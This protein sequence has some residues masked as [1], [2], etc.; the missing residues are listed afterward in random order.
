IAR[1]HPASNAISRWSFQVTAAGPGDGGPLPIAGTISAKA[2]FKS[3]GSDD[4]RRPRNRVQLADRGLRPSVPTRQRPEPPERP[5][6]AGPAPRDA[7]LPARRSSP[8]WHSAAARRYR[9]HHPPGQRPRRST[10]AERAAVQRRGARSPSPGRRVAPRARGA[11]PTGRSALP[12]TGFCRGHDLSPRSR[13]SGV[14]GIPRGERVGTGRGVS[15]GSRRVASPRTSLPDAAFTAPTR[16][17]ALDV[18]RAAARA[19]WRG[20]GLDAAPVR[21]RE[22]VADHVHAEGLAVA[23][24]GHPEM[25][26]DPSRRPMLG[27]G[28]RHDALEADRSEAVMEGGAS[29]LRRETPTP[30]LARE[31]IQDLDVGPVRKMIEATL[32]DEPAVDLVDHGPDSPAVLSPVSSEMGERPLRA[33]R[34]RVG[35]ERPAREKARDLGIGVERGVGRRIRRDEGPKLQARRLEDG[36]SSLGVPPAR[37]W[38]AWWCTISQSP[39]R[40]D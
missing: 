4:A 12:R 17:P 34:S 30:M 15:A 25:L 2:S 40:R 7:L 13:A 16:P 31:R 28:H 8:R 14:L 11:R 6:R 20:I 32:A 37:M 3:L 23:L 29:G 1:P 18:P 36:H 27:A 39:P 26:H 22:S 35:G 24:V 38:E 21:S 5:N 33:L 10:R 19:L 9:R